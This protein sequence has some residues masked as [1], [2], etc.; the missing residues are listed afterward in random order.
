[1]EFATSTTA[2]F[3]FTYASE[4]SVIIFVCL[5]AILGLLAALLGLAFGVRYFE[6]ILL[7]NRADRF[8]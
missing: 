8:P 1:M 3:F 6:D 2:Q 7:D 4:I 5:L